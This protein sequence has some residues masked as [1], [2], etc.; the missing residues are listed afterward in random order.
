M[1]Y[2]AGKKTWGISDRSGFRYRLHDM[3][4]EWTGALV[5]PDEFETKQPQLNAP[6]IGPD[7]QAV[8]NARPPNNKIPAE[9]KLPAFNLTSLEYELIPFCV[10]KTGTVTVGTS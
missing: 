3:K 7:P 6:N 5:G 9:V 8:K 2:A 4:K 10:G 1:A